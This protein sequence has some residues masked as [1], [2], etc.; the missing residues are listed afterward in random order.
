[1]AAPPPDPEPDDRTLP[2]M[3]AHDRTSHRRM[4]AAA[5]CAL[6]L[7][8]IPT[9]LLALSVNAVAQSPW[10]DADP[11]GWGLAILDVETTGLE[12][13]HHEMI[14]IGMIYTTL[15]G[16]ELGRLFLRI[17][18]RHPERAGEIARSINGYSEARWA[19]LDA[20]D[21]ADAA[22]R[23]LAFHRDHADPR[24][25]ILTAYNAPFDRA[26]LDAFLVRHG[27]S[28]R[29][30]YTYFVLDLPS[31][32]FGLGA[33]ALVNDRVAARFGVEPETDDP[34]EHTGLS[35]AEWNLALYRAMLAAAADRSV[36]P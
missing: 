25:F 5:R 19:G 33:T 16:E 29:D 1:M 13:G 32:A 22:E 12:P 2:A 36:Q 18:P 11:D 15:D 17:H 23:I 4:S 31:M 8:R 24:R 9:L 35:G 27:A 26:F 34:L 28:V 3:N 21:P 7:R 30:L 10:P 20:L 6:L 14:D